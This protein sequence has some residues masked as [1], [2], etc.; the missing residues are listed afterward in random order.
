VED[1]SSLVSNDS[2]ATIPGASCTEGQP[3][4]YSNL[5]HDSSII[6]TTDINETGAPY[7]VTSSITGD[8][9]ASLGTCDVL[10]GSSAETNVITPVSGSDGRGS[11]SYENAAINV[12]EE[13]SCVENDDRQSCCYEQRKLPGL[14]DGQSCCHEQRKLP[15][16]ENQNDCCAARRGS[17]ASKDGMSLLGPAVSAENVE[18]IVCELPVERTAETGDKVNQSCGNSGAEAPLALNDM[19]SSIQSYNTDCKQFG[20]AVGTGLSVPR[21]EVNSNEV[22]NESVED[23]TD[24]SGEE[25]LYKNPV[26][27]EL[28]Q[29]GIQP[30]N[31]P[32]RPARIVAKPSRFRDDQFE[33]EFRPGPRKNKVRQV[34]LNSEKGEP[35][36]VQ[37]RP[38]PLQQK[39]PVRQGC[40]ILREGESNGT[41][42]G[43]SKQCCHSNK[44]LI[45]FPSGSHHLFRKKG[46]GLGWPTRPKIRFKSHARNQWKFRFRALNQ[47]SIRFKPPTGSCKLSRDTYRVR[48]LNRRRV[49]RFRTQHQSKSM[50][51]KK[52]QLLLR[53]KKTAS[54]DLLC[55]GTFRVRTLNRCGSSLVASSMPHLQTYPVHADPRNIQAVTLHPCQYVHVQLI[56]KCREE[57]FRNIYDQVNA[58]MNYE[59]S[60]APSHSAGAQNQTQSPKVTGQEAPLTVNSHSRRRPRFI[61]SSLL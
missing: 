47:R 54:N 11:S 4:V 60:S 21:D 35:K 25:I 53:S 50:A 26:S 48:V 38:P 19:K 57:M 49:I 3:G 58:V 6:I 29:S 24:T 27:A 46:R 17:I 28:P 52:Q 36:A 10:L 12:C 44:P 34:H 15:D 51:C 32:K 9:A 39:T 33:T 1:S 5:G 42:L 20:S 2:E 43:N 30:D 22:C 8:P 13:T 23:A 37:D 45:Q 14:E 16:M 41:T 7:P 31:T 61:P 18:R 40:Q 56:A 59:L 55:E